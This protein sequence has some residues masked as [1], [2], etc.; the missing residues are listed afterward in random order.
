MADAIWNDR[1]ILSNMTSEKLYAKSPL[2]T[3]V[4][5]TSAYIGL[6]PSATYNETVLWSGTLNNTATTINFTESLQNF[7]KIEFYCAPGNQPI[8]RAP[9]V[10][11][12]YPGSINP[13]GTMFA[14]LPVYNVASNTLTGEIMYISASENKLSACLIGGIRTVNFNTATTGVTAYNAAIT[15]VVGI[16]RKEV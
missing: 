7:E 15:K 12:I 13:T 9:I 14:Y 10:N 2:T 16:N 11:T 6:E 3:G 4:S 1:Y 5:G 8:Q